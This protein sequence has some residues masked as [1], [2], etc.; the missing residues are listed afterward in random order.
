MASAHPIPKPGVERVNIV[1]FL[2]AM[3]RRQ[4]E[5]DAII[6]P[7]KRD[8]VGKLQYR[9][10]SFRELD[11]E[12]TAI[13][14]GLEAYGITRGMRTVLMVKPSFEFFAIAFAMFK[15]GAV[16][17][18]VDPG[19]GLKNLKTCLGEAEPGAFIG[20]PF[21]HAARV[22]L[23]WARSTIRKK[24]TV[25]RRVFWGGTTL[26]QIRATGRDRALEPAATGADDLAAILFTSGSTGVPKGVVYNHGNFVAQVD[27]I[28]ELYGIEPG[29]IDLPT[30][31]LFALFDP[32]LGMTAII[33]DMDPTRPARVVP[34]NVIQPILDF[35]VT[36]MFGS[37]ALLDTVGRH[38]AAAGVK[39]PSLKRV[40]SAG[41]PVSAAI[42][43]RFS[44]MLTP[45]AKIVTPYG[46]TESLPV[47][48][49]SSH[50]VLSD[51]RVQTESGR[52]V[53]V[54]KP[55]PNAEVAVIGIRDEPIELWS[56]DLELSQ[57]EIGEI[58]VKGPMVTQAYYN[59]ERSTALA[60][61]Q[62]G[63]AI[64]HR[65]GDLGYFDEQ[66][67]LW[68]CGR[69]AH[70]VEL[71]DGTLFT[72]MCEGIFNTHPQVNRCALV[73]V[74]CNG[75][76]VPVICVELESDAS[77][78]DAWFPGELRELALKHDLTRGI[79]HFLVHS[80]FPVDI[81]HNAKIDRYDLA[82]WAQGRVA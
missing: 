23:G 41:A 28:R 17:V 76:R 67:R 7:V 73:G 37:P 62:D 34:E 81:R 60:K 24:V 10:H 51:T 61:I 29:E 5:T 31:P 57:G 66:G 43:E 71:D 38:G 82:R 2:E 64:R 69:K 55:A 4:P 18:L 35:G 77:A 79:A 44:T 30:F 32:A 14:S 46:A 16:P 54:G 78:R 53:C 56:D 74:E 70:R 68:F 59:R 42:M 20:I 21:A 12:A 52:G 11:A 27:A 19:I 6:F 9:H 72:V 80:G 50:T 1:T 75:H 33:P 45:G 22:L 15:N 36:N 25:G 26:D 39:L 47:T 48:S 65:M 13:A 8:A 63:Q 58:V 40:I 3:A 49:V